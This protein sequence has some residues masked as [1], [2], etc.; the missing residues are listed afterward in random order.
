M[1]A[2]SKGAGSQPNAHLP[3]T[4][5]VSVHSSDVGSRRR[6]FPIAVVTSQEPSGVEL[7]PS[8][9]SMRCFFFRKSFPFWS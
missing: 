4:V 2:S 6:I 7:N 3:G 1:T 5:Q 8:N 9:H